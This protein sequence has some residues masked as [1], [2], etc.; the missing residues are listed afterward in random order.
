MKSTK[1]I[2]QYEL[3]LEKL[4]D[5]VPLLDVFRLSLHAWTLSY[6][7]GNELYYFGFKVSLEPETVKE[8]LQERDLGKNLKYVQL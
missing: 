2:H 8:L 5:I 4:S 7:Q 3:Q 1:N 6:V